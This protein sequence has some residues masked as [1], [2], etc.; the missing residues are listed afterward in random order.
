ML[1]HIISWEN[2]SEFC[3]LQANRFNAVCLENNISIP[4]AIKA[5]ANDDALELEIEHCDKPFQ[6]IKDR[7]ADLRYVFELKTQTNG[8]FLTL[9]CH[10]NDDE[11][12]KFGPYFRVAHGIAISPAAKKLGDKLAIKDL[13]VFKSQADWDKENAITGLKATK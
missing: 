11:M 13:T 8:Y 2:L 6:L 12:E 10:W 1:T 9:E 5:L 3:R 4:V 7:F